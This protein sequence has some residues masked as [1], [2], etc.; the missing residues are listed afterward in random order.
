MID[1]Q[2]VRTQT[3]LTALIGADTNLK[4]AGAREWAGPCPKCAGTDRFH[5]H[6]DKGW[7]CRQ[8]TGEPDGVTGH[9]HDAIDYIMWR[10]GRNFIDAYQQLGG[11]ITISQQDKDRLKAE[12]RQAD[13][14]R[15]AHEAEERTNKRDELNKSGAWLEYHK[16]LDTLDKRDLWHER[17]LSDLWIN[18]F[19]V[20]YCPGRTF[21]ASV[22][23]ASLTIPTFRPINTSGEIS[24]TCISLVH[25]L[26]GD[27]TPGG[28]YRPHTSGLGKSLFNC[29][30]Y[31]PVIAG[32]VLLVEGEI[33]AMVTWATIQDQF[34]SGSLLLRYTVVGVSGKSIK[35]EWLDE[36]KPASEVII[37]LDPDAR[38][39]AD[40]AAR[41]IGADRARVMD[42]PGKIDDLINDGALTFG[43]LEWYAA[44]ARRVN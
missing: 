26:I 23:R 31:S 8:C 38:K 3:D 15:K 24:W 20:G 22:T 36:L 39:E 37:C 34:K 25:R 12:R 28:K 19:Q 9:W 13:A 10:D 21:S 18:Y 42:L 29:D 7:F 2:A 43:K 16:N 44:T 40:N 33:K 41:M 30:I 1:T 6:E 4:R 27:D 32:P 14:A 11:D 17:G 5:L 35:A